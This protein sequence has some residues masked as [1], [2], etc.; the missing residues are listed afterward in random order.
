MFVGA[1]RRKRT[2]KLQAEKG[3]AQ[4]ATTGLA[5]LQRRYQACRKQ[6]LKVGFIASGSL[7][8]RYTAC[9]NRGCHCHHDPPQRHGPYWQYTRKVDGKTVT[10]RLTNEQAERY[11]EWID[12]RRKLDQ[13]IAEMDQVSQKV[14][15]LLLAQTP[16][17]SRS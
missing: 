17:T 15:D 12:N 7:I 4:V 16:K 14:R 9:A 8:Q 13:I 5:V 2:P 6:L 10:A 3:N 1:T 11:R